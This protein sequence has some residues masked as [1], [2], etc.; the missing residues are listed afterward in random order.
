MTL[1]AAAVTLGL[2]A[3]VV[4]RSGEEAPLP[5]HSDVPEFH[6][7]E[8]RGG[9]V[10]REDLLGRVWVANFI[11]TTC[12]SFCPRLTEQMKSLQRRIGD[13]DGVRLVSISVD[14]TNDTPE[15]LREYAAVHGADDDRWL[16]LTGERRAVYSL[17]RDGFKLA[18]T[19]RSA[20]E[21]ADGE[22]VI[23]HSDRFV[24]VDGEARIRGYYHGTDDASI[25]ELG[26]AVERLLADSRG[27]LI[28]DH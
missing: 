21:A 20:E 25:A 26:D 8:S 15:R 16:F 9:D 17:V 1:A 24:L 22:G 14:P 7:L 4:V 13:A 10:A 19:E 18:V 11:F 5:V 2:V 27:T 12:P 6:L 23:V 3:V 28:E